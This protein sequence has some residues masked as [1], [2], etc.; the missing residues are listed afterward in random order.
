MR[1]GKDNL[2]AAEYA[3]VVVCLWK[4]QESP[5]FDEFWETECGH[6]WALMEGGLEDNQVQFCPY[7]GQLIKETNHAR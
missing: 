4:K 3:E 6:T 7:C 2:S 5:D 1:H